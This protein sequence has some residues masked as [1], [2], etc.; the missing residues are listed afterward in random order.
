MHMAT[1]TG[2][3]RTD[4]CHESCQDAMLISNLFH[5]RFKKNGAICR[6]QDVSIFD[7]RFINARTCFR[8]K[9]FERNTKATELI[10]ECAHE[11]VSQSGPE[12]RI[13]E[14]AGSERLKVCESLILN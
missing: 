1:A 7:G 13:T 14:H 10:E 4:L 2:E 3:V 5:G 6:F 12:D 9:T 8:M 11:I